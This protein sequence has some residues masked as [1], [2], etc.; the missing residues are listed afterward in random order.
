MG[1][2]LSLV[3]IFMYGISEGF[4]V[5]S[6]MALSRWA[7]QASLNHSMEASQRDAYIGAYTALGVCYGECIEVKGSSFAYM[8]P[9]G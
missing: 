5:G 7:D 6:N 2:Y 9:F 8:E 3:S 1:L 4:L